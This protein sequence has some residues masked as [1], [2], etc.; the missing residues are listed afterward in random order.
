M[1]VKLIQF[2]QQIEGYKRETWVQGDENFASIF[3]VWDP[4]DGTEG[5]QTEWMDRGLTHGNVPI[6]FCRSLG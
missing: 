6:R 2:I 4:W 5:A 1:T 3:M